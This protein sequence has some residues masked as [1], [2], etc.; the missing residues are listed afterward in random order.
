[1]E[2]VYNKLS[3]Q[4][5]DYKEGYVEGIRANQRRV[6]KAR[7]IM[8]KKDEQSEENKKIAELFGSFFFGFYSRF[9]NVD[10]QFIFRFLYLC[11]YMNYDN[12]ISDGKRLIKERNLEELFG[13]SKRECQTTKM[14]FL[15]NDMIEVTDKGYIL[16]NPNICKKGDTI[17]RRNIEVIRM[18][19]DSIK[20]LY[21]RALPREHKKLG[22]LVAILPYINHKYNVLCSNPEEEYIELVRPISMKQLCDIVGFDATNSSK[23]KKQLLSLRVNRENVVML[24]EKEC[25]KAIFI[26]PRVYYKDMGS[27]LDYLEDMFTLKF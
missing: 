10:R 23:L 14:V 4:T 26:N 12:Y 7:D 6:D 5:E 13:L 17:V 8:R 25:G 21:R 2:R 27:E 11:S 22:L 24:C 1:M 9:P 20:E 19:Q 15:N 16:I 18:F 3:K